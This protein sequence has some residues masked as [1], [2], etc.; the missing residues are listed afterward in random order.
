MNLNFRE[1]TINRANCICS[2]NSNSIIVGYDSGHLIVFR[3]DGENWKNG[4]VIKQ[5]AAIGMIFY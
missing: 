4:A 3:R 1:A 5:E 2:P